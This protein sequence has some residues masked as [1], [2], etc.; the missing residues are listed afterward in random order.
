LF[1]SIENYDFEDIRVDQIRSRYMRSDGIDVK[2]ILADGIHI[3][4]CIKIIRVG[5]I[6]Y[7]VISENI[8]EGGTVIGISELRRLLI[9]LKQ[10]ELNLEDIS[11]GEFILNKIEEMEG[12][13][14]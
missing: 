8:E 14:E 1:R 9:S 12:C 3:A 13:I 5:D 2:N 10:K 11:E 6:P 4:D 7:L